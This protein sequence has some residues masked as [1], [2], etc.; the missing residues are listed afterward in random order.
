VKIYTGFG[1]AGKTQLFSGQVVDKDNLK[2]EAYGT[3][4][5]LNS[6]LGLVVT[7]FDVKHLIEYFQKIQG[8][9][10]RLSAELA[11]SDSRAK[12][13][14]NLLILDEDIQEIES[15]IDE[16]EGHLD[17]LKN[18]ILPGGSRLAA[19]LHLARTVCRRAER[20]MISL[21]KVENLNPQTLIYINRLS[22]LLFVFARYMNHKKGIAD[23]L[24]TNTKK[25]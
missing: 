21:N 16:I 12:R 17:S 18:F 11:S 23:I 8:I 10:F 20:R 19:L 2:V 9:L 3:V 6:I 13:I 24:W 1:D 22:D 15:R 14:D 7:Y 5:E 4:D 25:A